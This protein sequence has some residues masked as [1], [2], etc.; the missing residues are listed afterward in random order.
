L[1]TTITISVFA[2]TTDAFGNYLTAMVHFGGKPSAG[3][4]NMNII[5]V[6]AHANYGGDPHPE[7]IESMFRV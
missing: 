2:T 1:P 3:Q 6:F 4:V 5:I 7:W